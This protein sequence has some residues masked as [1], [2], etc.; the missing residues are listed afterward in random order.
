VRTFLKYSF[1]LRTRTDT[2]ISWI[3]SSPPSK[4][5]RRRNPIRLFGAPEPPLQDPQACCTFYW[6]NIDS[7]AGGCAPSRESTC[8]PILRSLGIRASAFLSRA[9]PLNFWVPMMMAYMPRRASRF[10]LT[11]GVRWIT[12]SNTM[13][14]ISTGLTALRRE[15]FRCRPS[16]SRPSPMAVRRHRATRNEREEVVVGEFESAGLSVMLNQNA[17]PWNARVAGVPGQEGGRWALPL[18][19]RDATCPPRIV[20]LICLILSISACSRPPRT[21]SA[22]TNDGNDVAAEIADTLRGSDGA[23]EGSGARVRQYERALDHLVS[24][25]E[26]VKARVSFPDIEMLVA[27]IDRQDTNFLRS[28]RGTLV[29]TVLASPG[30]SLESLRVLIAICSQIVDADTIIAITQELPADAETTRLRSLIVHHFLGVMKG[31]ML[32]REIVR[33]RDVIQDM[34]AFDV[35][36]EHL[37]TTNRSPQMGSFDESVA[38]EAGALYEGLLGV[39]DSAEARRF[40]DWITSVCPR[41]TTYDGLIDAAET[42]AASSEVDRLK[43]AAAKV[44]LPKP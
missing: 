2:S 18:F 32:Y 39:G 26:E 11:P 25:S 33:Q 38:Q 8:H 10:Q 5:S 14:Y 16:F 17:E 24:A 6:L 34:L 28:R 19:H 31:R 23:G 36:H 42:V 43:A 30:Q 15:S 29:Q 4:A 44:I 21:P 13:L 22:T 7:R 37:L 40:A 27:R 41:E 12:K 9:P 20:W 3:L 35:A 1:G